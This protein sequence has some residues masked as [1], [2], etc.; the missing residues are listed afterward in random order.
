MLSD[1]TCAVITKSFDDAPPSGLACRA[2]FP[3]NRDRVTKPQVILPLA[4]VTEAKTSCGHL[5]TSVSLFPARKPL[6]RLAHRT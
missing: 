6:S 5:L 2:T 3:M 1:F 4:V